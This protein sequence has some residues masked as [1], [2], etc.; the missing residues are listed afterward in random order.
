MLRIKLLTSAS[1]GSTH[2]VRMGIAPIGGNA[3]LNL[4]FATIFGLFVT[5]IIAFLRSIA[6][7]LFNEILKIR[8]GD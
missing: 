1:R 8:L 7:Q 5:S 4:L 6:N 2:S 3:A